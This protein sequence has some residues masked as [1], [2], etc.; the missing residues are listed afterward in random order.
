MFWS[1]DIAREK[2][3]PLCHKEYSTSMLPTYLFLYSDSVH[4]QQ[5]SQHSCQQQ[6][7][8]QLQLHLGAILPAPQLISLTPAGPFFSV[9]APYILVNVHLF[10]LSLSLGFSFSLSLSLSLSLDLSLNLT[11][12]SPPGFVQGADGL[13]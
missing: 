12:T 5:Y 1:F 8:P 4:T 10:N 7:R 11:L 2:V 6:Q 13:L 9:L 3:F